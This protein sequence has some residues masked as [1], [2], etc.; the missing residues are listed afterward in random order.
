M[1]ALNIDFTRINNDVNGNPRYVC[2]FLEFKPRQEANEPYQ[3]FEY[4]EALKIAKDLGGKKFHNKQY[5]GGIVFQSY[6]IETLTEKI[7]VL[8]GH[9]VRY[10]RQPT[11]YEL[12]KGYGAI[13]H[14]VFMREDCINKKGELKKWFKSNDDKLNYSRS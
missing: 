2:H 11:P 8:T 3:K 9:A 10:H 13:H 1:K 12:K 6:N 14:R 7:L 4:S 5:G